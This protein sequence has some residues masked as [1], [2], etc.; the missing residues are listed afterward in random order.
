[1]VEG[2]LKGNDTEEGVSL[3]K[4]LEPS[5]PP[6][7]YCRGKPL[8]RTLIG[9]VKESSKF[10]PLDLA[11]TPIL[12]KVYPLV[13]CKALIVICLEM[14]VLGLTVNVPEGIVYEMPPSVA[15][16]E[17]ILTFSEKEFRLPILM[18]TLILSSRVIVVGT[19]K[20]TYRG[21]LLWKFIF[22]YPI[23]PLT[24]MAFTVILNLVI[25]SLRRN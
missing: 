25:R 1:M 14:D 15:G 8:G 18:F 17:V 2:I 11:E 4:D 3:E 21:L 23:A 22:L 6:E 20:F 19:S 10:M 5:M 9:R 7:F 16:A 13:T 12:M 24:S